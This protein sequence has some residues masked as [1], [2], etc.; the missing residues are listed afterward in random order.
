M[1]KLLYFNFLL[2]VATVFQNIYVKIKI[3]K[4]FFVIC[5]VYSTSLLVKHI[6]WTC[7]RPEVWFQIHERI[8]YTFPIDFIL[9][10]IL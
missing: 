8:P 10:L 6:V 5:L 7:A 3:L 1:V 2:N 4:I 9:R